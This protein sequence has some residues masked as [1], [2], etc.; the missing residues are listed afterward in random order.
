MD[1]GSKGQHG[2]VFPAQQKGQAAAAAVQEGSDEA[3]VKGLVHVRVC[4]PVWVGWLVG[5]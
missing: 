5:R 1:G 4:V 3:Y 2:P